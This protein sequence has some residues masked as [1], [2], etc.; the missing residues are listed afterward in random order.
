MTFVT[1]ADGLADPAARPAR[2]GGAF[3]DWI[4]IEVLPSRATVRIGRLAKKRNEF[5]EM[6][7]WPDLPPSVA[8]PPLAGLPAL[9]LQIGC[10]GCPHVD[11]LHLQL[12]DRSSWRKT[13]SVRRSIGTAFEQAVIHEQATQGHMVGRDGWSHIAAPGAE[14]NVDLALAV[15]PAAVQQH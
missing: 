9:V 8:S 7:K 4:E 2:A 14:Q 5:N 6:S 13:H 10:H 3:V 1:S 11:V 12:E 15:G